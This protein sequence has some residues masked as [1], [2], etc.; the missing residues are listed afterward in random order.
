MPLEGDP[1]AVIPEI[2]APE[3]AL[4]WIKDIRTW[5]APMPE[6]D[7]LSLAEVDDLQACRASYGRV[8]AELG[9]EMALRM[10]VIEFLRLRDMLALEHRRR[11]ALHLG[12]PHGQDRGRDRAHPLHLPDR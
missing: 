8:G 4:T 2:G 9:R 7:G 3:M 5:P 12:N 6:D 10:P 1:I 11:L